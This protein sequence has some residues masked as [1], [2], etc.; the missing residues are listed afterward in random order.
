MLLMWTENLSVGVKDLDDDHKQLIKMINQLHVAIQAVG[1]EGELDKEEL[2]FVLHRLQNYTIYHCDKEEVL[3]ETTGYPDTDR[4]KQQHRQLV[5]RIADLTG[6][7]HNSTD[8]KHGAEIMQFIYDWLTQHI[9]Q[10]DKKYSTHLHLHEI[11]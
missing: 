8:P 4:H 9:Y 2:E 6:R 11:F 7:F 1:K 10:T 5:T 3:F